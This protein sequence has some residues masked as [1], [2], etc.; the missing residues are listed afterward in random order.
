MDIDY[1]GINVEISSIK[2][3]TPQEATPSPR[4]IT[5]RFTCKT[6]VFPRLKQY[7]RHPHYRAWLY[8][9]AP[10]DISVKLELSNFAH[11]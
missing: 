1:C 8:F 6:A 5:T 4:S 9:G 2:A 7:Y 11:R 3:V 10:N